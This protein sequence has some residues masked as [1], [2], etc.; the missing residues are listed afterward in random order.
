MRILRKTKRGGREREGERASETHAHTHTNT[1]ALSSFYVQHDLRIVTGFLGSG[2]TTLV[3]R[4]LSQGHRLL[5][6]QHETGDLVVWCPHEDP[7]S[8]VAFKTGNRVQTLVVLEEHRY[9][10]NESLK[11]PQSS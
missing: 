6:I 10:P 3:N 2:K 5:V 4:I 9:Q 1:S 7:S 8:R 11:Q